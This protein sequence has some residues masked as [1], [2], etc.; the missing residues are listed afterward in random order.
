MDAN[1]NGRSGAAVKRR[2]SLI[3]T[4]GHNFPSYKGPHAMVESHETAGAPTGRTKFNSDV[5]S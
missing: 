3:E 5:W 4:P 1:N 2:R